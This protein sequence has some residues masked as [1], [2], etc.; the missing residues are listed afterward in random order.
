VDLAVKMA[1]RPPAIGLGGI[2]GPS[3]TQEENSKNNIYVILSHAAEKAPTLDETGLET[4]VDTAESSL[5]KLFW[6]R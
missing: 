6:I 2:A 3:R 1:N 4:K 5:V